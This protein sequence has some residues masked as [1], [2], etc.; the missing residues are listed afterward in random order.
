[1]LLT[2]GQNVLQLEQTAK[3]T[4]YLLLIAKLKFLC[5]SQRRVA[6]QQ[7]GNGLLLFHANTGFV[8][9]LQC[10]Y[11]YSACLLFC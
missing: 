4:R 9:T 3:G 11:T 2:A 8:K 1:M 6:Q 5:Y 10:C 7:E